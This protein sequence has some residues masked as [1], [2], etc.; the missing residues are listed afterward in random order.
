MAQQQV[1]WKTQSSRAEMMRASSSEHGSH[2]QHLHAHDNEC[3]GGTLHCASPRSSPGA[4]PP[5]RFCHE[6]A[7]IFAQ[8]T[9]MNRISQMSVSSGAA[10][11][12]KMRNRLWCSNTNPYKTRHELLLAS[13]HSSWDCLQID[14]TPLDVSVGEVVLQMHPHTTETNNRRPRTLMQ[15]EQQ[16]TYQNLHNCFRINAQRS[17]AERCGGAGTSSQQNFFTCNFNLFCHIKMVTR[18]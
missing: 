2:L 15:P 5:A 17:T 12:R 7:S 4:A 6:C 8:S 9:H 18:F 13:T 14:N 1:R 11:A 16:H 10:A 3:D